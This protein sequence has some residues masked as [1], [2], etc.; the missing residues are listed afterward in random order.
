MSTFT[1]ATAPPHNP[2]P[3]YAIQSI[4]A[5]LNTPPSSVPGKQA[6]SESMLVELAIMINLIMIYVVPTRVMRT[7][8][9]CHLAHALNFANYM[10]SVVH[11]VS[12]GEDLLR[13][14]WVCVCVCVRQA[15]LCA[16]I[17]PQTLILPTFSHILFIVVDFLLSNNIQ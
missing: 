10:F 1:R 8:R 4:L 14:V 16:L 17:T 9:A 2:I 12:I 15:M 6:H 11:W 5:G 3:R 13:K 7:I